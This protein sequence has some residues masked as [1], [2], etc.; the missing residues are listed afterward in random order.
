[1]TA[2]RVDQASITSRSRRSTR[3]FSL[4]AALMPA[5]AP[6]AIVNRRLAK[7]SGLKPLPSAYLM[8]VKLSPQI[9][10]Q[11]TRSA[12]AERRR[13]TAGP[14]DEA[15][16]WSDQCVRESN[17]VGDELGGGPPARPADEEA[18]PNR[19][20]HAPRSRR[21]LPLAREGD[22]G[23]AVPDELLVD[24]PRVRGPRRRD[25]RRG[26]TRALRVGYHASPHRLAALVHPRVPAPAAG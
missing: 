19:P 13:R 5:S 15:G 23:G 6:V 2:T 9:V 10:T 18:R 11:T 21:G 26:R 3:T 22:G 7:V 4:R 25:L 20:D 12:S 8:T 24:H 16:H 1:F 14:Y 17:D